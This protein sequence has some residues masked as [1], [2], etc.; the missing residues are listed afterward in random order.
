VRPRS[1]I[2]AKV[3]FCY[4]LNYSPNFANKRNIHKL[5]IKN[6]PHAALIFLLLTLAFGLS[7]GRA[8][9]QGSAGAS[10]KGSVAQARFDMTLKREGNNLSGSY[11]YAKSGSANKLSLRGEIDAKGNFTLQEFD[12]SGKQTGEFKGTWKDDP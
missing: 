7:A 3:N 6:Y 12:P 4:R 11:F 2:A 9:A 10:F 5:K 1:K 8:D